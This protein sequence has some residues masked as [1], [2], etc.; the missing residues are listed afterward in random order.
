LL[1]SCDDALDQRLSIVSTP[2]VLAVLAE[3]AEAKPGASVMY[4]AIVAGPDGPLA[5]NAAWSFCTTPKAPTEDNA[6]STACVDG[7][8]LID[9]GRGA[10]AMGKVPTDACLRF[11]PDTPP[12][13]PNDP[14]GGFRP[15]DPDP[16][17][18]YYLPVRVE[19]TEAPLA[20]GLS[21]ITCKLAN[22]S[23]DASRAY[24]QQY[25]ANNNPALDA[26]TGVLADGHAP[27]DSDVELVASWPAASTEP[28]VSFD[29][30][31]QT[32]VDRR[33]AM[34]VSWYATAGEL[35]VDSSVVDENDNGTTA[36]T[37]WH[38]PASSSATIWIVLR[39]SRGGVAV[40]RTTITVE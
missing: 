30:E 27:A 36:T 5:S 33:E 31:H 19:T 35:A 38:T 40:A 25:V 7:D 17:G 15:R 24:D 10:T 39:D 6:V 22:A 11:G 23:V 37:T 32:L 8:G 29:V 3:P 13:G 4:S 16:T 28:Y 1:A 34:R 20:F 21:R 18:G 14:P 9:L 2:R 12:I 26:L